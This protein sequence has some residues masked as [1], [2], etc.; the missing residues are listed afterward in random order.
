MQ[1][2][3]ILR[4]YGGSNRLIP[5]GAYYGILKHRNVPQ[6]FTGWYLLVTVKTTKFIIILSM[7]LSSIPILCPYSPCEMD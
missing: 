4:K 2:K 1:F 5:D 3:Q 7:L 6:G